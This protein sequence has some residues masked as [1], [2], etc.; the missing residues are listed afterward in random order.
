MIETL[1]ALLQF[2]LF[3]AVLFYFVGFI[4]PTPHRWLLWRLAMF[5]VVGVFVV[6]L[7]VVHARRHPVAAMGGCCLVSAASYAVL[8]L[9]RAQHERARRRDTVSPFLNLRVAGKR[10][11]GREDSARGNGQKHR[12]GAH[13]AD[14]EQ[15]HV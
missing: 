12:G 9:R 6:A 2:G 8:E 15:E 13:A 5:L 10:V 11:V 3:C 7:A 14:E 4:A 1:G